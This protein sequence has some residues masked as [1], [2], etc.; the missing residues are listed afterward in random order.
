AIVPR[1]GENHIRLHG[2]VLLAMMTCGRE[3]SN[4]HP[5]RDRDLNPARLPVPPRPRDLVT[6][7]FV[8]RPMPRPAGLAT[9]LQPNAVI[10]RG[11]AQR[12]ALLPPAAWS[13]S[14]E[15]TCPT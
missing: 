13:C 4:L 1:T 12:P 11:G 10:H 3:D 15:S 2:A 14:H 5:C 9:I 7:C 8:A 6:C